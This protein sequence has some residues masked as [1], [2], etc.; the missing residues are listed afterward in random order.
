MKW[1][2]GKIVVLC[3]KII[4]E[5]YLI[6]LFVLGYLFI[7]LEGRLG[8]NKAAF[9]ILCRSWRK[10]VDYRFCCRNCG[11]ELGEDQ[12]CMVL[13]EYHSDSLL[14]IYSRFGCNPFGGFII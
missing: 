13:Q 9:G 4:M 7:V 12:L 3:R 10:Y 14:G 1:F 6:L 11:N 2:R 8:I 5:L